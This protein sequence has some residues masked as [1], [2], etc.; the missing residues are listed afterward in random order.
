[1]SF[2]AFWKQ[3]VPHYLSWTPCLSLCLISAMTALGSMD[4]VFS[5]T[6]FSGS[7]SVN[8]NNSRCSNLLKKIFW[9]SWTWR[10][11]TRGNDQ[12]R[13]KRSSGSASGKEKL[14]LVVDEAVGGQQLEGVDLEQHAVEEEIVSGGT[15]L[16]FMAQTGL[17]ELL[18]D[19]QH[20]IRA[21]SVFW[22]SSF[23][24]NKTTQSS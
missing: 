14:T 20:V 3:L 13:W 1:M 2:I 21:F 17:G 19:V 4:L 5:S 9:Y 23:T 18:R 24:R 7:K 8:A 10:K 6:Q 22:I 11:G 12:R 15:E 16:G